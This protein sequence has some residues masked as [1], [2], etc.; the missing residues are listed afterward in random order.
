M[1]IN[2]IPT[3]NIKSAAS[4]NDVKARLVPNNTTDINDE[5]YLLEKFIELT[6]EL[7]RFPAM[8]DL[9]KKGR[10]DPEFPRY[11]NFR[12]LRSKSRNQSR[13]ADKVLQFC[14]SLEGYE[15]IRELCLFYCSEEYRQIFGPVDASVRRDAMPDIDFN[16]FGVLS[17]D[18][19]FVQIDEALSV[20]HGF[21]DFYLRSAWLY[22]GSIH[23]A[24][25]ALN[26]PESLYR[27][28]LVRHAGVLTPM[29]AFDSFS[30]DLFRLLSD[31]ANMLIDMSDNERIALF[32]AKQEGP[33]IVK[34]TFVKKIKSWRADRPHNY[35]PG[36]MCVELLKKY[37]RLWSCR[38]HPGFFSSSPVVETLMKIIPGQRFLQ[39]K[40]SESKLYSV[41]L[42]IIREYETYRW[43]R[44]EITKHIDTQQRI[45]QNRHKSFFNALV[46]RDGEFCVHCG[47]TENLEIDHRDPVSLGGFSVI[48]NLQL[49][50]FPCNSEKSNKTVP[51]V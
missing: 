33:S 47:S 49:L 18:A 2:D 42:E 24:A 21:G 34:E 41:A 12:R 51:P 36:A 44:E 6:R 3:K 27:E 13:I 38:R 5:K 25:H 32:P 8:W 20:I 48:D 40:A 46:L 16:T 7:K 17:S 26:L 29:S 45:I 50:C 22:F 39:N 15:D 11:A 19:V 43:H 28:A 30:D 23:A 31:G 35:V 1:N 14:G 4:K 37:K 10:T 9:M